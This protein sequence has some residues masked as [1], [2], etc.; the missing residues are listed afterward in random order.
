IGFPAACKTA[1]PEI[2]HKTEHLGVKLGLTDE[3]AVRAAY[4]DLAGRLGP[5]VLVT[6]MA[7]PGVEL[8]LGLINDP[9]F[10]PVIMVGAGG[11]L[12]ELLSDARYGVAPFGPKAARRLLDGLRVRPV[13]NGLRGVPSADIAAT[14]DAIAQFS[15]LAADLADVIDECDVNPLIAGPSGAVAVGAPIIPKKA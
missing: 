3:A 1:M 11:M 10:G 13:L 2:H 12:V 4:R 14:A 15:V 7:E 5:R 9:Q 8:A 6:R